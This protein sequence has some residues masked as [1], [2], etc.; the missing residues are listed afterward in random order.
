MRQKETAK[1]FE[2]F[3]LR[4]CRMEN[5]RIELNNKMIL[6]KA[7][8]V[9]SLEYIIMLTRIKESSKIERDMYELLKFD[10]EKNFQ[11]YTK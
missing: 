6:R 7:D 3:F 2:Y 1:I 4:S 8:E 11:H 10:L 9:D 5:E